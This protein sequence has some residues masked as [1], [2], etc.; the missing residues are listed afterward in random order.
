LYT[1]EGWASATFASRD[2]VDDPGFAW[3]GVWVV[4]LMA[5]A[6]ASGAHPGI[7]SVVEFGGPPTAREVT[8]SRVP[9]DFR[10]VDPSGNNGPLLRDEGISPNDYIVLGA[11]SGGA[12]GLMPG[13]A[14]YYNVRNWQIETGLISCDPAI[15]RCDARIGI[16]LPH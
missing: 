6:N 2:F 5:P 16:I 1:D 4:K 8:L 13:E 7:I 3:N 15:K 14:Y 11:S 9:C 12:T 10:P